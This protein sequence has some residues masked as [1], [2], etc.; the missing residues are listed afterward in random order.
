MNDWYND[1]WKAWDDMADQVEQFCQDVSEQ[2]DEV[3][4]FLMESTATLVNDL[5]AAI[6]P[7]LD[8]FDSQVSQ[9]LDP[10]LETFLDL[11]EPLDN[12][13]FY[14]M[15]PPVQPSSNHHPACIGCQHYHG[16]VYGSTLLVC[17]MHPYGW[18]GDTCP[19][20][21]ANLPLD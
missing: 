16:Q 15:Y 20:W 12:D 11:D 21:E 9:W 3:A 10:I 14:P 7:Q 4:D 13:F 2:L 5:E 8:D 1:W 6:A 19:D 17:G 18:D